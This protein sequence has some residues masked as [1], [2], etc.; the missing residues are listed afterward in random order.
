[1]SFLVFELESHSL[2]D[3]TN[4]KA[5]GKGLSTAKALTCHLGGN[6]RMKDIRDSQDLS[7]AT[8]AIFEIPVCAEY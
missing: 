4:E 6:F 5:I 2:E 3:I 7:V 1:M 8:E